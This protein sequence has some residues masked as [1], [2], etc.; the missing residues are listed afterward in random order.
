MP[1][2]PAPSARILPALKVVCSKCSLRELC[3]PVGLESADLQKLDAAIE[4]RAR[5]AAGKHVYRVRD[6]FNALY[7][8]RSGFFKT[9][10]INNDG[11]E[12]IN[13]FHMT[14]EIMGLDAI[15]ADNHT[16]NAIALE[17]CEVCVI[18]FHRLEELAH[19]IP[20]LM[21]QI[22]RLMSREIAADHHMM[23]LLGTRSAEEKLAAFLL[24]LSERLDARGLS[25]TVL[26]LSMS[27]EEIGNYLGLKL[28]TVSRTFSKLQDDGVLKV[29]R[30]NLTLTDFPALRR[31][32]GCAGSQN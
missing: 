22:H 1:I 16:C 13:G 17:D 7:A 3:L 31:L 26:R 28:E 5:I 32:A 27:R 10:E 24:N 19:D 20:S 25:P 6:S 23:L 18:P 4:R 2:T 11:R 12:Q 30:R 21:R 14:G 29:E 8:V 9:Y 15:S